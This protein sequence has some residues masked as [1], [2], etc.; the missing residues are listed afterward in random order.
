MEHLL[1]LAKEFNFYIAG[2]IFVTYVVTDA[3]YAKYTLDV[4]N[5]NKYRAATIG[6]S[7][8]FLMAFGVISYTQNW[9]YIIPL[10]M[11]SW[12]GTFIIVRR[13]R[14]KKDETKN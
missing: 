9:F 12:V 14:I 5:Y 2:L 13:E 8:H 11:G 3:L 7:I 1:E 10:A 6:T 4:A